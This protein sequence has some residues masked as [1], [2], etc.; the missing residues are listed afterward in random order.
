M[1]LAFLNHSL[2][3]QINDIDMHYLWSSLLVR[4]CDELGQTQLI[5][6]P[7][8]MEQLTVSTL[9]T[10]TVTVRHQLPIQRA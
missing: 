5:M 3:E 1:Y 8:Q 6:Q 9:V 10:H 4:I 7:I 2:F